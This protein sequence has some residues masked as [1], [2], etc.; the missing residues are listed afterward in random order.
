[1][2]GESVGALKFK[3]TAVT[4]RNR[5]SAAAVWS[6]S[7]QRTIAQLWFPEGGEDRLQFG[8][9]VKARAG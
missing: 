2:K 7:E 4:G 8:S 3:L 5:P 1:M 6:R 9:E